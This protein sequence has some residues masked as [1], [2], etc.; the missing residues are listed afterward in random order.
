M[1]VESME[2]D[3]LTKAEHNKINQEDIVYKKEW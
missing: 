3:W 2:K 1:A